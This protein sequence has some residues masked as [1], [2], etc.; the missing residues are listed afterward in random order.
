MSIAAVQNASPAT[1]RDGAH[2][3]EVVR[4]STGKFWIGSDPE[5]DKFASPV[6]QPRQLIHIAHSFAIGRYPITFHEWDEYAQQNP[7]LRVVDDGGF[8]RGRQPVI[9]VC[10]DEAMGYANW[11]STVTGRRYRLPSEAEWEY[12]CRAG[13][14]DIFAPGNSISPDDANFLY[15]DFGDRPGLGRPTPVGSYP[16][17]AFGLF[18]MHGNVVELV[19]DGWFGDYVSMSLDGRARRVGEDVPLRVVRGGGWDGLP[20]ILRCAFRDWIHRQARYDNVGFR[21]ACDL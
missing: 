6:E 3:P 18:D 5:Q 20:R 15:L 7:D 11:L 17:N 1:F 2:L 10:W 21:V 19:E 12:C 4:I 9:G 16:A 14:S 8:G 13:S